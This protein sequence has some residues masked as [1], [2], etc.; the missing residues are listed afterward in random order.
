MDRVESKLIFLELPILQPFL[1]FD[2]G[3]ELVSIDSRDCTPDHQDP[4]KKTK[5][6]LNRFQSESLV[7]PGTFSNAADLVSIE[8]D[9][10]NV[11]SNFG[12]LKL[13][14]RGGILH[15]KRLSLRNL[16]C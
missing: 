13:I 4:I 11:L 9:Q 15:Y 12:P 14:S 3:C 10:N 16:K 7:L 8:E 6:S 5:F 2:N 1:K